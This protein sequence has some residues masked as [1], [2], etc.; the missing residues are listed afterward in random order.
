MFILVLKQPS[1]NTLILLEPR[2]DSLGSPRSFLDLR[3]DQHSYPLLSRDIRLRSER[4]YA[5]SPNRT[6][7]PV[8]YYALNLHRTHEIHMQ[9]FKY[10]R[11]RDMLY[12]LVNGL[13]LLTMLT[14]TTHTRNL[15]TYLR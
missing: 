13:K 8:T 10:L 7:I 11:D 3:F 1:F 9:E 6:T 5:T 14:K 12:Y 2:E 15:F 4:G